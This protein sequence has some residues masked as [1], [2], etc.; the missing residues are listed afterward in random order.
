MSRSSSNIIFSNLVTFQNVEQ[1]LSNFQLIGSSNRFIV[2]DIYNRDVTFT[3]VVISSNLITSNLN[4]IGDSTVLNT[5]VYQTEQLEIFNENFNTAVKIK[6]T[7]NLNNLAEF[8][9]QS[10]LTFVIDKYSNV[11]IGGIIEPNELLHIHRNFNADIGIK[12]SDSENLNGVSL[13][14]DIN[15][16][17]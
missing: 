3:G 8:Y 17:F 11:G 14:K 10:N 12:L 6:Q 1:T 16:Y 7:R 2:N 13:K 4:V 9:N 15:H 5:I